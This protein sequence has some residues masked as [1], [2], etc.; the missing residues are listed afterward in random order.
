MLIFDLETIPRT[1]LSEQLLN[2]RENKIEKGKVG[3][4]LKDPIKIADKEVEIENKYQ[5]D[6]RELRKWDA[7][8]ID[9]AEIVAIGFCIDD[10]P[11]KIG[12]VEKR[13]EKELLQI[14][15]NELTDNSGPIVTFN[16]ESYDVPLIKRRFIAHEIECPRVFDYTHIDLMKE[17]KG[18]YSN[19]PKK[20]IEYAMI[21]GFDLNLDIANGADVFNAYINKDFAF[22]KKHVRQ[23]I[24]ITKF[25]LNK[26][27]GARLLNE[28][29]RDFV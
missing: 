16:G 9:Y 19:K 7:V 20:L 21:F 14:F 11:V 28:R 22:I 13:Y 27:K 1:D 17:L 3:K 5:Y 4:N 26:M 18:S 24:E 25:L 15:V 8:D 29:I 12:D 10:N 6:K 2:Y 23:D